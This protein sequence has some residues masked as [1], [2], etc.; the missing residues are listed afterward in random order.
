MNSPWVAFKQFYSTPSNRWYTDEN[1]IKLYE[2]LTLQK[3]NLGDLGEI[4]EFFVSN[5]LKGGHI[6]WVYHFLKERNTK[7]NIEGVTFYSRN[8][9]V[10]T[11]P[12]ILVNGSGDETDVTREVTTVRKNVMEAEYKNP[13]FRML[14]QRLLLS[15]YPWQYNN[16]FF[17]TIPLGYEGEGQEVAV[18]WALKELVLFFWK[19]GI[20]TNSCDQGSPGGPGRNGIEGA[21]RGH[22]LVGLNGKSGV[23]DKAYVGYMTDIEVKKIKGINDLT[24]LKTYKR[25]LRDIFTPVKEIKLEIFNPDSFGWINATFDFADLPI[26]HKKFGLTMPNI[27][28]SIQ[29][30]IIVEGPRIGQPYPS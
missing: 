14:M 10:A 25:K 21:R 16:F 17:L 2:T 28:D 15:V 6:Q 19:N 12:L 30:N 29:G 20:Y 1:W 23:Y 4:E 11:Y 3:V 27:N 26:I 13:E 7:W 24:A 5:Y 8:E 18:D 22:I 9:I